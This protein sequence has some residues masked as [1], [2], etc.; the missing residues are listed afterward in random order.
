MPVGVLGILVSG[1]ALSCVSNHLLGA[2]ADAQTAVVTL[3]VVDDSQVAIQ[4]DGTIG[5]DLLAQTAAD[6]AQGAA[7]GGHIA[8]C[9]GGAG[10]DD[11]LAVLDAGDDTTGASSSTRMVT[12]IRV[13]RAYMLYFTAC[14]VW[15]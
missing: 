8:L 9:V 1:A 2:G 15:L 4:G 3:G 11:V 12:M 6:A 10:D 13:Q 14:A 7:A 5:T